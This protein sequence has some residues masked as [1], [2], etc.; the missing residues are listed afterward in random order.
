MKSRVSPSNQQQVHKEMS[1]HGEGMHMVT[2]P[3]S[4]LTGIDSQQ[5]V[6]AVAGQKDKNYRRKSSVSLNGLK[7]LLKLKFDSPQLEKIYQSYFSKRRRV[8]LRFLLLAVTIYNISQLAVTSW[9]YD[10]KSTSQHLARIIITVISIV[11]CLVIFLIHTIPIVRWTSFTCLPGI[12]W[13]T[14]YL[15]L[16]LDLLLAYK[17]L[18]PDDSVG[19][20]IFFI[21]VTYAMITFRLYACAILSLIVAGTH[22]IVVFVIMEDTST[23]TV[24]RVSMY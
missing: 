4:P 8:N 5:N 7:E 22:C 23:P 17:P 18:S 6:A 14:V 3:K 15:Q 16:V 12:L 13:M 21:Y 1:S 20:F 11:L 24:L 2:I 10:L 19:L 9:D